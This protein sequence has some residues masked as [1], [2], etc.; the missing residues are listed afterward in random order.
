MTHHRDS[1]QL[2]ECALEALHG[3]AR[4]LVMN[5]FIDGKWVDAPTMTAALL[6]NAEFEKLERT[7]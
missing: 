6:I 3:A 5:Y 1:R 4:H 7:R 2:R